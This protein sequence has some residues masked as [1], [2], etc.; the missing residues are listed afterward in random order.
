MKK[1]KIDTY[2]RGIIESG[3]GYELGEVCGDLWAI[4]KR[5]RGRFRVVHVNSGHHVGSELMN[6]AGK[7]VRSVKDAERYARELI[8]MTYKSI[9]ADN[10]YE[11][12]AKGNAKMNEARAKARAA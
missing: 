12:I 11:A 7:P 8:V 1:T 4:Q 2:F 9:G 5:P 10:F 6:E 3:E